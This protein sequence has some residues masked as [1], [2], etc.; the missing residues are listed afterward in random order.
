[1]KMRWLCLISLALATSGG[2]AG[3]YSL[4]LPIGCSLIAN[5][6]DSTLPGGNTLENLLPIMPD[7]T[8]FFKWS[9][10]RLDCLRVQYG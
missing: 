3:S 7:G 6:L 5:Q 9:P 1:M 8:T 4:T 10:R 2:F